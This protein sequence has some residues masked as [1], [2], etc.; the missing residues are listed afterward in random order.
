TT[1]HFI[2][3]DKHGVLYSEITLYALVCART[4]YPVALYVTPGAASEYGIFKL[5]EFFL[6]PKNDDFKRNWGIKTDWVMPCAMQAILLDNHSSNASK[7]ALAI[8]RKLGIDIHYTRKGRGDDKPH[9]ERFFG[10]L[11]T[12]LIS[13]MP[14][15]TKSQD[16]TKKD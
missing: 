15:A 11:E 13:K 8:V 5:L 6:I 4:S 16:K 2:C 3:R 10:T 14:G 7:F 12:M 1:L 9:V